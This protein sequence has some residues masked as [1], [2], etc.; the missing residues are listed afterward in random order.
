[1]AVALIAGVAGACAVEVE[2]EETGNEY[3][4][5]ADYFPNGLKVTF[6]VTDVTTTDYFVQIGDAAPENI[7][8][9]MTLNPSGA[10]TDNTECV[11]YGRI[12][13]EDL[14]E[15]T[16]VRQVVGSQTVYITPDATGASIGG[17]GSGGI[18]LVAYNDGF[19]D[20]VD[21]QL[22]VAFYQSLQL[23]LDLSF[24][25]ETKL[26]FVEAHGESKTTTVTS[27]KSQN[28][29][30]TDTVEVVD[31]VQRTLQEE[32]TL[33]L[34]GWYNLEGYLWSIVLR[35]DNPTG[36]G[37]LVN[38]GDFPIY[39]PNFNT[40][41]RLPENVAV[42]DTWYYAFGG[43]SMLMSAVAEEEIEVG[44]NKILALH[45]IVRGSTQEDLS[46]G[47]FNTSCVSEFDADEFNGAVTNEAYNSN[48]CTE[49]GF[50]NLS[51]EWYYGGVLVKSRTESTKVTISE[52]GYRDE[53]VA[54]AAC[55]AVVTQRTDADNNPNMKLFARYS[56]AKSTKVW[57]PVAI[58]FD[59]TIEAEFN[60]GETTSA[61]E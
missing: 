44:D 11:A 53:I 13:Q 56:V 43:S 58:E 47:V 29:D 32:N 37:T 27:R 19:M 30:V 51:H 34:W 16:Q 14:S 49:T 50:I 45:V 46:N 20:V 1:M 8:D 31:Q 15:Q 18:P 52:L 28:N 23:E 61:T 54:D 33:D 9:Y 5:A 41:L 4:R 25:Q 42:G 24:A 7:E 21:P 17:G 60:A 57:N 59:Q 48:K 39:L 36:T 40:M 6:E 22:N 55:P 10:T 3:V 38:V 12:S 35:E 26:H 2:P